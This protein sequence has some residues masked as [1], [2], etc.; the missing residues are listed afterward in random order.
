MFFIQAGNQSLIPASL[1]TPKMRCVIFSACHDEHI[2]G[3]KFLVGFIDVA[4]RWNKINWKK[5]CQMELLFFSQKL[6]QRT[7][8]KSKLMRFLWKCSYNTI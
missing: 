7:S 4:L 6:L 5:C 1:K 2:I 3:K 8:K